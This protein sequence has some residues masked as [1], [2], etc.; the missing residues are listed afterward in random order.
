MDSQNFDDYMK[1]LGEKTRAVKRILK[2]TGIV[3]WYSAVH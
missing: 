2:C 3:V 1:E